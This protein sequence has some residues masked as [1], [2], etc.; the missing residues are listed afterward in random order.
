M[1]LIKSS[2][3]KNNKANNVVH[4][5]ESSCDSPSKKNR[6]NRDKTYKVGKHQPE[7]TLSTSTLEQDTTNKR[8]K[9]NRTTKQTKQGKMKVTY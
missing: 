6:R 4:I 2:A 5:G 8:P 9:P 7:G 1:A 3:P